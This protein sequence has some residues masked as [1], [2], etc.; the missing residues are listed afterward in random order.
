MSVVP[1]NRPI[2]ETRNEASG[3]QEAFGITSSTPSTLSDSVLRA[4]SSA[5]KR[6][7]W[8]NARYRSSMILSS[9]KFSV[10]YAAL[11]AKAKALFAHK[12]SVAIS[13]ASSATS[14]DILSETVPVG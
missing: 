8:S 9:L 14:L 2:V 11:S 4:T 6:P 3:E 7:A 5:L 1:I 13:N 10:S 12:L